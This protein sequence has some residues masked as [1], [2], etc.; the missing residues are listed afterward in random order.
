MSTPTK[1]ISIS[2]DFFQNRLSAILSPFEE[3]EH[4]SL[5]AVV[6]TYEP[7]EIKDDEVFYKKQSFHTYMRK[8]DLSISEKDMI[9]KYL[10]S[11][12]ITVCSEPLSCASFYV[13]FAKKGEMFFD[14][15]EEGEILPMQP[16]DFQ[17]IM[18]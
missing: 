3:Y 2:S 11:S 5:F 8:K 17:S 16:M 12:A 4:K 14:Y 15:E 13:R 1:Y 9:E 18:V 7:L 10:S 6:E